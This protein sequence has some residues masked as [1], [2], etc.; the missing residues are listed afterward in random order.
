MRHVQRELEKVVKEAARSFAA[1]VLTGPR[2]AGKTWLLRHLFPKAQYYLLEDPTVIA[3]LR[4]DPTGF[5]DDIRTPVILD[6][7]QNVPEIL[8]LVRARIDEQPRSTGRWFLTGSQDSPLMHGVT[9]SMAG[10]AAGLQLRPLC[11]RE[12][13]R[14]SL[15]RGGFLVPGRG[16]AIRLVECKASRTA[17]PAMARPMQRLAQALREQHS[18]SVK[19][20][21]TL[22]WQSA[23][24]LPAVQ[25]VAP[26][27]RMMA[28]QEFVAGL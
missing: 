1:V 4:S 5:L 20:Q 17:T 13:A 12:S 22:V 15:L 7:V 8:A 3:R 10:R 23:S 9:E 27:V 18:R 24:P 6:E 19:A 16:G 26:G 28:W 11:V 14:V 25:T 21:M 2:R